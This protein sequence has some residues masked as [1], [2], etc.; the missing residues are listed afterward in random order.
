M[1]SVFLLIISAYV[2]RNLDKALK[3]ENPVYKTEIIVV[4]N[5]MFEKHLKFS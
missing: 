3:T 1:A 5:H 2:N 4:I